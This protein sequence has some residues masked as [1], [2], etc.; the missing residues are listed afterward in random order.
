MFIITTSLIDNTS[1]PNIRYV[2]IN[3]IIN[4]DTLYIIV[5]NNLLIGI[6][7]RKENGS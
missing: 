5:F 6:F 3:P 1:S 7:E 2:I 4:D